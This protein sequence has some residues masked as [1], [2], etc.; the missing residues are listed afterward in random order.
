MTGFYMKC[1]AEL[2][3]VNFDTGIL[4]FSLSNLGPQIISCMFE[5][6]NNTSGVLFHL[7]Q[8]HD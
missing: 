1:N 8:E 6:K 3:C 5:K 7:V 2:K 4:I